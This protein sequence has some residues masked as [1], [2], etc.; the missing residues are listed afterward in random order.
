MPPDC[1][2]VARPTKWGNPFIVGHFVGMLPTLAY[3][4][5]DQGLAVALYR[6]W[7]IEQELDLEP[8]RGHDLACWCKP[9]DLCHADVLLELANRSTLT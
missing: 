9:T 8:L 5:V 4:E 2:S 3:V 6:A 7:V 1:I